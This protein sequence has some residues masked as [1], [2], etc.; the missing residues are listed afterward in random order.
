MKVK[1]IFVH[2]SASAWGDVMEFDRWHKARGWTGVGYHYVILNGRP[3]RDVRYL[4]VLDG[5]IQPGRHL[6]DDPIYSD[7]EIG[8]HVAGRNSSSIGVCLVGDERFTVAQFSSLKRLLADLID[9]FVLTWDDVLGHYEDENTQK[10]CPNI[11][12]P[13]LRD[14]MKGK[15]DV[16]RL[17]Q[18]ISA[19]AS[20]GHVHLESKQVYDW[21]HGLMEVLDSCSQQS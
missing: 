2:C 8:A 6:D 14:F 16:N 5:Q 13:A 3:F 4:E 11:P 12:M 18:C 21:Y 15:M 7:D 20:M 1:N 19:E 10:T 9:R 17:I